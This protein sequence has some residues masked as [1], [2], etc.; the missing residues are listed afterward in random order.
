ML[1][2]RERV[3]KIFDW[4]ELE[5]APNT[6]GALSFLKSAAEIV[7]IRKGDT[8]TRDELSNPTTVVDKTT[9]VGLPVTPDH[10]PHPRPCYLAQDGHSLGET[11]LYQV[12]WARAKPETSD[13]RVITA[14]WRTMKRLCGMSDKSCKRN[15]TGLIEKFALEVVSAEDIA[16]RTGRTYRIHS[17]VSILARRKAAGLE[18]VSRNRSRRFV[19][20]D[21]SPL[22]S[23]ESPRTPEGN[24][25][26]VDESLGTN[27]TTVAELPGNN[28]TTVVDKTPGTMVDKTPVTVVA[29]TTVLGSSLGILE[30]EVPSTT[31]EVDLIVQALA[32]QAGV[33]DA[34]AANRLIAQCRSACP[35]ATTSEIVGIVQEKAFAARSR[36][37]VRNLIGFL[38]STVPPVFEGQGIVSYRR[39]IAAE[40]EAAKRKAEQQQKDREEMR[41]YFVRQAEQ[42]RG[43]LSEPGLPEKKRS[44]LEGRLREYQDVLKHHAEETSEHSGSTA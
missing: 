43:L 1:K 16:T 38:L 40:A 6:H 8:P 37:D 21:G 25:T 12:L 5:R 11:A 22:M 44:E 32:E 18:W 31:T 36:R 19:Q 3:R 7:S 10:R 33:A 24:S 13:T 39:M 27:P 20:K 35:S 41:A 23:Q 9:V 30:E 29:K 14:G 26:T 34:G 42:L 2:P 17:Y 15:T 28:S 4:E